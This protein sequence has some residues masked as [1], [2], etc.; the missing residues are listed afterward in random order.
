MS[1]PT[2]EP[3]RQ[4]SPGPLHGVRV[5]DLTSVVMGPLGTQ[6]LGDL[7]ADVVSIEDST[8]NTN[9]SMGPGPVPGLSGVSLNLLRNKRSVGLDLKAPEGRDA[10]LR[11]AASSDVVVT[12]LRPGP[13][14]RLRLAYDDVRAISPEIIFCQAHGYPSDSESADAP[15]YDDIIQSASGIGHL[16]QRQ[17]FQPSLL[18]TLVADKVAGLT[19]ASSVLAA[20]Y[21][22]AVTGEGQRIEVPMIDV[23]RAFVLIE[24]GAGAIAEPPVDV[25]GYR[26][27][28]TPERR[29]QPTSD[30]WL[31][32]LP[33]T[34]V[35]Y[36]ALFRAGNRLDLLDDPR[37]A[38]REARI[39]NSDSLYRDVA[40]ILVERTTEEWLAFCTAEGIPATRAVSLDDIVATLPVEDHPVAGRYRVIPHPVRYSATPA[41]VRRPAPTLGQHSRE[42][43]TE[44]GYTAA[45]IDALQAAGVLFPAE[46]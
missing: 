33:Y 8:G 34:D 16:F 25:A 13:L 12:N 37:I 1:S 26:R 2:V 29:P 40:T 14:R 20:L 42:V 23:M 3:P 38:T 39:A 43:L 11:L 17:G 46:P 10:F 35:H 5:L 44:A 32:V 24:H 9:R 6:V 41:S 36:H 22:R 21:H 7:G 19:I 18:P 31:N 15:A 30:S 45:E 4:P 28:L 27:I